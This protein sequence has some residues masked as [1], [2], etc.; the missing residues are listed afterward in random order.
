ML[1]YTLLFLGSLAAALLI[2]WLYNLTALAGKKMQ[3]A[4]K[5]RNDAGAM[6]LASG[7]AHG[8][9]VRVASSSAA[10][11]ATTN[12]P[13]TT[14][15]T[16]SIQ[17]RDEYRPRGPAIQGSTLSAYLARKDAEKQ[18]SAD[19]RQNNSRPLRDDRSYLAN[20]AYG[21]AS[22]PRPQTTRKKKANGR[23]A[24]KPWGW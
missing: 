23:A 24:P 4:K 5:L 14:T 16:G 20:S 8:R 2:L 10:P 15:W 12:D 3:R 6:P 13:L 7:Y 22:T 21:S 9:N 19:W 1:F 17:T 18:T 11:N